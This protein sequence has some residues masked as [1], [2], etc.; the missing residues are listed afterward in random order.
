MNYIT[1][2]IIMILTLATG[3][4]FG[5]ESEKS[6]KKVPMMEMTKDERENMAAKHEKLA[7]CLRSGKA[8]NDCRDEMMNVGDCPMMGRKYQRGMMWES[9]NKKNK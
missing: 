8:M 1:A 9:D 7:A 6:S 2:A 5:E 3:T 4:V